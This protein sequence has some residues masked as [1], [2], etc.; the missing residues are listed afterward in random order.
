VSI[1]AL[2]LIIN[3]IIWVSVMG[4]IWWLLMTFVIAKLPEPFKTMATIL[5]VVV[6]IIG[7]L[8]FVGYG[9]TSIRLYRAH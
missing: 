2:E 1:M 5:L 4:L 9:P 3:L 7:L 6:V 8:G